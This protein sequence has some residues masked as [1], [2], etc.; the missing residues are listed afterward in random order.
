MSD[1]LITDRAEV[2]FLACDELEGASHEVIP[3]ARTNPPAPTDG[4]GVTCDWCG[5]TSMPLP[6]CEACGYPLL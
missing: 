6:G 3:L 2:M 4:K 5:V 1:E